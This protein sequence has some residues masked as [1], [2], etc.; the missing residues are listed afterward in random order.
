VY[1]SGLVSLFGNNKSTRYTAIF[2]YLK[3]QIQL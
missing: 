3:H 1:A 2:Q